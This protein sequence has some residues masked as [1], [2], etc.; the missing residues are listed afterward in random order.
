M[1][2]SNWAS[3]DPDLKARGI[4]GL[5]RISNAA[6]ALWYEVHQDW[7]RFTVDAEQAAEQLGITDPT[8]D[9]VD[10]S[11]DAI[12]NFTGNDRAAQVMIRIGQHLFRKAVL[13]A[14]DSRC[15][16]TGL[17]TPSLLVASHIV[18]WRVDSENRLNPRNGLCLSVLH[19]RAFDAGVIT[20]S[21]NMTVS[22]SKRHAQ[23]AGQFFESSISAYE[24][25]PITLPE[26][27]L[28]DQQF[29]SY[30]REHIFQT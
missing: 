23:N 9:A 5:S 18:P 8:Q 2:L 11:Q 22:V 17:A 20:V 12:D 15:C 29:L 6:K 27:F 10:G 14:Y 7:N 3:L 4:K 25:R 19:D 13:D 30:H 1:K 26:E 28:P 16:I 24:G 21:E